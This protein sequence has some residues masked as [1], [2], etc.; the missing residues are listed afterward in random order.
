MKNGKV[1]LDE[2]ATSGT[3]VDMMGNKKLMKFPKN[4]L[5]LVAEELIKN[6]EMP[7]E[8]VYAIL[9]NMIISNTQSGMSQK[10]LYRYKEW[11]EQE[12]AEG[13]YYYG[14]E[15][16]DYKG[17]AKTEASRT[18]YKH[19]YDIMYKMA[20]EKKMHYFGGSGDKERG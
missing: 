7:K 15:I 1:Y 20:T 6:G 2:L 16:I 17:N 5:D 12:L 19:M 9:D 8:D 18:F 11:L 14:P 3:P 10:S 4:R 13:T